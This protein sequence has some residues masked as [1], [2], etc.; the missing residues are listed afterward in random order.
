MLYPYRVVCA[1][2]RKE[3]GIKYT[4]DLKMKDKVSHSICG[5]CKDKLLKELNDERD[6]I[7]QRG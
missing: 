7:R 4:D 2:C 3:M 5:N 1:S 6:I